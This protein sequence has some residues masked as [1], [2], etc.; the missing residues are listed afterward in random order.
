[1]EKTYRWIY[2]EFTA[3]YTAK[4]A[5]QSSISTFTHGAKPIPG[6]GFNPVSRNLDTWKQGVPA[7]YGGAKKATKAKPAAKSA[8][9]AKPAKNAS[10]K[11]VKKSGKKSAKRR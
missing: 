8:A 10:K 4:T 5:H 11:P 6:D 9:K 3:K 2:D 1:M 7:G